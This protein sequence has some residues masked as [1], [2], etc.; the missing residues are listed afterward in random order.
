MQTATRW[1][2]AIRAGLAVAALLALGAAAGLGVATGRA[3]PTAVGVVDIERVSL[4]L[5]ELQEGQQSI[6]E[7]RQKRADELKALSEELESLSVELQALPEADRETRG[8]DLS[9]RAQILQ[10][11][12]QTK[13]Q[14]YSQEISVK[15]LQI[16]VSVYEK[17]VKAVEQ[18]AQRDG[19]DL[20]LFDDSALRL[21]ARNGQEL[22][23]AIRGRKVLHAADSIDL[24]DSVITLMN[25][26]YAGGQ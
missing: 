6:N 26:E 17:V 11:D 12:V 4:A 16:R 7:L 24:S 21:E 19:V 22:F 5:N 10:A 13:E 23:N 18:V 14:V 2:R 20:V 9:I 8:V 25:N 3:V 1:G 15:E